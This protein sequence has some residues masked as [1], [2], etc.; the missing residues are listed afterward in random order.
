M[1][2]RELLELFMNGSICHEDVSVVT[3]DEDDGLEWLIGAAAGKVG[4]GTYL[5]YYETIEKEYGKAV[6]PDYTLKDTSGGDVF[7]VRIEDDRSEE[8]DV[9]S[10]FY[11]MWNSWSKEECRKAFE[12]HDWQHF[13]NKW[14]GICSCH[15]VYGAAERFYA[16]LS[17]QYRDL[18]VK[19]ALEVY[20]EDSLRNEI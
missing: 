16:E 11:Y 6:E 18:L 9:T 5:V 4:N 8:N 13:W 1:K 17:K 10:F 7:L 14:C 15:S 12:G 2:Q 3:I 19:R 20:R